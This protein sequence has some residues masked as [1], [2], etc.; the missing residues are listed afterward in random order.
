MKARLS[1]LSAAL[2]LGLTATGAQAAVL[3]SAGSP[4]PD[5]LS[6]SDMTF[7]GNAADDCYGIVVGNDNGNNVWTSTGWTL[8]AKDDVGGTQ[9]SGSV[10]GIQFTLDALPNTAA[11]SGTWVLSWAQVGTPGYDLTMDIVAVLKGGNRF[12]SYLFNQETFTNSPTRGSGTWTITYKNEGGQTPDLYLTCPTS[13]SIIKMRL[14]PA[15][16]PVAAAA[17][18]VTVSPSRAC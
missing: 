11:T 8:F 16:P 9:S 2:L 6:V 1:L 4:H 10:N 12:A 5:G 7:R 14:A 15:A 18:M 17:P 13:R 3:C